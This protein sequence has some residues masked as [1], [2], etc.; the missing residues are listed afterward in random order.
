VKT[1][2]T[3]RARILKKMNMKSNAELIRFVLEN[4][5]E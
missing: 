5:L 4:G 1:F 3:Y 2:G